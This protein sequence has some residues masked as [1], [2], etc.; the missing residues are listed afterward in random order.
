MFTKK[1]T[2]T[3]A[4]TAAGALALTGCGSVEDSADTATDQSTSS[5]EKWQAP[6][7]LSG[8]VDYYSANPQGL[9]D[10]LVEAFEEKT[11]VHVNVFA[12]TTGKITAKLKAE[13]ANPQADVVYLASWNAANKQAE[14]GNLES[15]KPENIQDANADW[16]ADDDT[17]HGR[18]GSALALVANTDVVSDIPSDWEDLADPKYADQVIMPDP[19]ESGTAADLLTA[20]IAEWGEDK[21]WELF[22]KLFDN[23][24]IVQGANGPALDQVTSGSKGIVFGG[25]DYSGLGFFV[26]EGNDATFVDFGALITAIIN[27]LLIAAVIYFLLVAPMNKLDEAQKRRKGID[28]EEPTPTETELLTEIRDLLASQN[29]TTAQKP[30]K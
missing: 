25:V 18:D 11:D 15:Y 16:N 4:T 29:P 1:F 9:T 13:E 21:T 24:M 12:D 17:F 2:A 27:F 3:I 7:G 20:M 14:T 19:R 28:P 8:E 6:E 23:G 26:R 5:A 10:A 22:D 30:L